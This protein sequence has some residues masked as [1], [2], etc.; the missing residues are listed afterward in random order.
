MTVEAAEARAKSAAGPR[1]ALQFLDGLR[2]LAA[3][4]VTVHHARWLL[5]E[6]VADGYNRHPERYSLF[7]K[8]L[9]AVLA[10][11]RFGHEAVLFFFVLSG[12]VI[13][14]GY[15]RKL[16]AEGGGARFGFWDYLWRRARRLYPPLLFAMVVTFL[17]D[18]A[19]ACPIYFGR[20]PYPLINDSIQP[21]HE[22]F[23]A[24]MNLTFMMGTWAPSWGT[25]EPL[26][27]LHF[28]WWFYM[29]YPL[30]WLV[31][32][33]SAIGAT[34]FVVVLA[35]AGWLAQAA[36][37]SAAIIFLADVLVSLLGWWMGGILADAYTG[38]LRIRSAW[39]AWLSP[40]LFVTPCLR[41][42]VGPLNNGLYALGFTGLLAGCLALR[43]RGASLRALVGLKPLGDMSYTLYVTHF[44]IF[45]FLSGWLMSRSPAHELPSHLGWVFAGTAMALLFAYAA[46]FLV[47]R[48]FVSRH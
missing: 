3:L 5:W 12:F 24:I 2:G 42:P 17:L 14:L 45:V 36:G 39:V 7:S 1:E 48:P 40:L 43:T 6:G 26:W 27:T 11:F 28:E 10:P 13:H 37:A 22:G 19:A 32:K 16:C 46:H 15:A 8:G 34:A 33:R 41:L 21:H 35:A 18:C 29:I 4:W 25:N 31:A 38:R 20:T 9:M 23:T 30:L 47:E 44:P